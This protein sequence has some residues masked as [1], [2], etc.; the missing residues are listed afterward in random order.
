MEFTTTE[1]QSLATLLTELPIT[2]GGLKM[3]DGEIICNLLQVDSYFLTQTVN[4]PMERAITIARS[5]NAEKK[6]EFTT[7]IYKVLVR[8]GDVSV[9][10]VNAAKSILTLINF[11]ASAD[12]DSMLFA[13]VVSVNY[14]QSTL[15]R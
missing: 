7:L 4:Y 2:N 10:E 15:G 11:N 5:M 12:W 8:N 13:I 1:K 9:S 14:N 3:R 6:T